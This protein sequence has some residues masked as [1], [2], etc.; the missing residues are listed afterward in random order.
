M[1]LSEKN[2]VDLVQ[3]ATMAII[4]GEKCNLLKI[5]LGVKFQE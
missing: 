2:T 3:T 1:V 5:L 4:S